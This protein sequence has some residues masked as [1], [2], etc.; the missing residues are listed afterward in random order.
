MTI[1]DGE[2]QTQMTFEIPFANFKGDEKR[3]L[4]KW[5]NIEHMML[6]DN[7]IFTDEMIEMIKSSYDPNSV[8]YK[9]DILGEYTD[10]EGA[11]YTVRD[12][13]ILDTVN[14]NRYEEYIT[15]AD[16]GE[17]RSG[18]SFLCIGLTYNQEQ[19]QKEI[20]VIRSYRHLNISVPEAQRMSQTQYA[21]EYT[22]FIKDCI[23][24]LH[25]A[26]KIVLYDGD[27]DFYNDLKRYGFK[28]S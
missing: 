3:S 17:T 24:F 19:Q 8:G 15:V 2:D 23:K 28:S 22:T 21:N 4:Q 7:P 9:R 18:T 27:I 12:Y 13:N 1:V 16:L 14:P 26:P 20:H 6:F 11:V 10:P 5:L 25:K